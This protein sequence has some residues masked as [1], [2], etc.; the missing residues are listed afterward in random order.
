MP[1]IPSGY[2]IG[3]LLLSRNPVT[4]LISY[5]RWLL[6]PVSRRSFPNMSVSLFP[7][8][9][10]DT[11]GLIRRIHEAKKRT[12]LVKSFLEKAY[13]ALRAEVWNLPRDVRTQI[14]PFNSV[15]DLSERHAV[16]KIQRVEVSSALL[17]IAELANFIG[18]IH[19][20]TDHV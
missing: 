5:I 6:A 7:D 18:Y 19:L 14:P 4:V 13:S 9:L 16:S 2:S 17:V 20:V 11:R 10:P 3:S 8:Q 15:Y 1:Y 12:V